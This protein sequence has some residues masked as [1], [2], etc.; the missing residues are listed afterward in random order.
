MLTQSELKQSLSYNPETGIFHWIKSTSS[1]I[2]INDIAGCITGH[3][4]I[5][6]G[7]SGKR[8]YAHRLAW[9]YIHGNFPPE[10]IDHIN[11]IRNDNRLSNLRLATN[12]ENSLN[13]CMK[14]NNKSG[15]KGV[16][17]DSQRGLWVARISFN[18]IYKYIGRFR[19]AKQASI[20]YDEC[21]EKHHN[22]FYYQLSSL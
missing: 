13:S 3:G 7:V 21:A 18:G 1:L 5:F 10:Q 4:Y 19:T 9:L 2:K 17:F 6:I 12:Q 14:S 11:N 16:S 15:Y 22:Q 8:Y 20:A